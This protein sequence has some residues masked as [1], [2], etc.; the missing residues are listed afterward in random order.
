MV[1]G[2][3]VLAHHPYLAE[4]LQRRDAGFDATRL[5]KIL[6]LNDILGSMITKT[7]VLEG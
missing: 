2:L 4:N 5:A 6:C 7:V 3:D 1:S